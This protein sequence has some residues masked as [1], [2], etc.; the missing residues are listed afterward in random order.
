MN[1]ILGLNFIFPFSYSLTCVIYHD[2]KKT[3]RIKPIH[4]NNDDDD[5]DDDDDDLLQ[6]IQQSE[7]LHLQYL[8]YKAALKK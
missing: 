8:H 1:I 4:N 2:K 5:D 3:I 6:S 7:A